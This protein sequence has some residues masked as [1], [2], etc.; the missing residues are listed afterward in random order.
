VK[1][2]EKFV[3]LP[4]RTKVPAPVVDRAR[5]DKE[6]AQRLALTQQAIA[7]AE[8]LEAE[9][10]AAEA[11]RAKPEFTAEVLKSRRSTWETA[12][13]IAAAAYKVTPRDI[14][15]RRRQ[16]PVVKARRAAIGMVYTVRPDLNVMDIARLFAL[17]HTTVIYALQ[18]L[19]L[20]R[21]RGTARPDMLH[22]GE[23]SN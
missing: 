14:T 11:Q 7:A 12:V 18:K 21:R 20:F 2:L 6:Y 4:E 9:R 3:R 1:H 10:A 22:V 5:V 8:A 13:A 23:A 16:Q 19:G 15:G 17:D